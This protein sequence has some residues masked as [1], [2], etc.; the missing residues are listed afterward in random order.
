MTAAAISEIVRGAPVRLTLIARLM[1]WSGSF[2]ISTVLYHFKTKEAINQA[3]VRLLSGNGAAYMTARITAVDSSRDTLR[4]YLSSNLHF[5]AQRRSPSGRP[6]GLSCD[7]PAHGRDLGVEPTSAGTAGAKDLKI[8]A[9]LPEAVLLRNGVGPALDRRSR[10]LDRTT[11]DTTDQMM[12][13][14]GRAAA[15]RRFALVGPDGVKFA[16]VGHELQRAIHRGKADALAEM[17]QVVVN[18]LRC[19]EVVLIGKDLRDCGALSSP[20]LCTRRLGTPC[21]RNRPSRHLSAPRRRRRGGSVLIVVIS[22]GGMSMTFMDEV[23]VV[24]MLYGR[25]PAAERM[26]VRVVLG[27][28]MW[29][30]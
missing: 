6:P 9:D 23:G 29:A 27:D 11:T 13:M 22:M 21:V 8:V 17:S 30:D 5:I 18:L 4:A 16:G 19:A 7:P 28:G 12:M 26:A 25:M 15:V 2:V 24:T 14:A 1:I 3:V 20:A 10:D